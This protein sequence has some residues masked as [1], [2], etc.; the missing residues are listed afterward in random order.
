MLHLVV[1]V[2]LAAGCHRYVAVHALVACEFMCGVH[3]SI[4]EIRFE[5]VC[6]TTRVCVCVCCLQ[7][8]LSLLLWWPAW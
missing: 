7:D 8:T 3:N 4:D 5:D 2:C 6:A 1:F